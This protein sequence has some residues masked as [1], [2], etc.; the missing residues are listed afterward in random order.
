MNSLRQE[1]TYRHTGEQTQSGAK[2]TGDFIGILAN[3]LGQGGKNTGD[4]F[5]ILANSL[6]QEQNIRQFYWH[7][8]EQPRSG[9]KYTTILLAYWRTA[10]VRDKNTG[11]FI[12]I[13]ENSLS[14]EQNNLVILSAY[15]R[16]AT[17]RSKLYW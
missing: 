6:D 12:C 9:A 5:G 16:T 4:F 3:S 7:I 17:V 15:W 13:L 2:Y 10:S 11:D 8:G 1:Q 14:Q